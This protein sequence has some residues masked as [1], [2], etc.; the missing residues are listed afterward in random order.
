MT[1]N[2]RGH[3][4]RKHPADSRPRE[5]IVAAVRESSSGGEMACARA[6]AIAKNL[7]VPAAEV[8][9]ACDYLEIRIVKCQLGLFGYLPRKRVVEP[10]QSVSPILA[11]A[12]E[13]SL[14]NG[15]LPC[16][17]AWEIA[18]NLRIPKMEVS[19]ACEALKFKV[20]P[21]QLGAF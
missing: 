21:C 9:F 15:R 7:R 6:F 17:G 5:D 18:E 11:E 10:A 2:D 16:K 20:S 14:V 8:G 13:K 1:E 3:Y 12:I 4:R 19:S